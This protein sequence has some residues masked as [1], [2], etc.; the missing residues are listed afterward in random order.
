MVEKNRLG[1]ENNA[2]IVT[3]NGSSQRKFFQATLRGLFS[4]ILRSIAHNRGSLFIRDERDQIKRFVV[5]K[6]SALI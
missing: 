4:S 2:F 6:S 3:I 5:E 1:N